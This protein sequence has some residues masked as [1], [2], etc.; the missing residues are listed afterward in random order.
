MV[1]VPGRIAT[2]LIQHPT[3]GDGNEQSPEALLFH[4]ADEPF[5]DGETGRF[6]EEAESATYA[7]SRTPAFVRPARELSSVV[8]HDAPR[9]IASL[10][11]RFV[12][13]PLHLDRCRH[14][15]EDRVYA[16]RRGGPVWCSSTPTPRPAWCGCS[17]RSTGRSEATSMPSN[18]SSRPSTTPEADSAFDRHPHRPVPGWK[19]GW[20]NPFKLPVRER[21]FRETRSYA[22]VRT[23]HRA[24]SRSI[25]GQL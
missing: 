18:G 2:K 4:R 15:L 7:A 8:G 5:D 9:R 24:P 6:T 1:V 17:R 19:G 3:E 10:G 21:R 13:T 16:L 23:Y 25:L 22:T 11:D 14:L 12:E 20:R